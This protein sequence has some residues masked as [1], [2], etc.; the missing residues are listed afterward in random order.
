ME[1]LLDKIIKKNKI[2]TKFGTV[3]SYIPGLNKAKKED[4][5]IC[6]LDMD[7]NKYMCGNYNKKF[8]IQSVSKP[9]ALML[10][11]LDNG[12]DYVFSKVGTEPTGDAFNSIIRLET[13]TV[14]KPYNPM[15]N[16]GAIA[17]SS[18]IKGENKEDKFKRLLEFFKLI[19][20]NNTLT[21][22]EEIY[23]GENRTGHKNRAMAY[24]MKDQGII[25]S[26]VED[27]LDVYFKQCSIEVTAVDLAMIG[28]FLARNGSLSTGEKII[29]DYEAKAIKS[30]MMTCGM[31]DGSGEFAL[32]VG[33]P[34]KSGVGGGI[35]SVLPNKLGIGIYGP[36]LDKKGNSIGGDGILE[37]LSKKLNLSIF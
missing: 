35:M 36:S 28:M 6:L 17:V 10:A 7:G 22:N 30:L 23:S 18:M 5:G 9:I 13:A 24:F 21:F 34:S 12:V 15:I 4:L 26:S 1:I 2:K 32:K 8:T 29:S 25:E 19:T 20:E 11:M 27:G 31:Y 3:A 33:I 37:D 16:A 14:K